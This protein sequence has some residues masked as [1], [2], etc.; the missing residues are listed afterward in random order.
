MRYLTGIF[1]FILFISCNKKNEVKNDKKNY[2]IQENKQQ[3]QNVTFILSNQ[4][5]GIPISI[6]RNLFVNDLEGKAHIFSSKKRD[7]IN[8]KIKNSEE[9]YISSKYSYRDTLLVKNGDAITIELKNKQFSYSINTKVNLKKYKLDTREIDSIKRKFITIQYD[10]PLKMQ[11]TDYEKVKSLYPI[12][13]N[14]L[15]FKNDS[16]ELMVLTNLYLKNY[17]KLTKKYDS[18]SDS[19]RKSIPNIKLLKDANLSIEQFNSLN[20]KKSEQNQ[21]IKLLK[22]DL[23]FSLFF[24]LTRLYGYS[25]ND[26][27]KELIQSSTFFNDSTVNESKLYSK[28][29]IFIQKIVLDNKKIRTKNKVKIDYI[30]AFDSLPKY[31]KSERNLLLAMIV[32]ID[33]AAKQNNSKEQI[34]D[35]ISRF[36][37]RYGDKRFEH[38]FDDFKANYLLESRISQLDDKNVY[39]MSFDSINTSFKNILNENIGKLIYVDFW[40][41]WCAPCRSVMP[42]AISL[43]KDYKNKDV[44]F[45]YLSIDNNFMNWQKAVNEDGMS[46][47]NS[48][49]TTNY[50]KANFYKEVRLEA[51]PRYLFYDKKGNLIHQNAP[52]PDSKEI[53]HLLDKYLK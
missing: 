6:Y 15:N 10:Y 8:F 11:P 32:C 39:L 18:I 51:I 53:R 49:I 7:T 14:K 23:N 36:E 52:E 20:K 22:D 30:Q 3:A 44:I 38:Y 45:L 47:A 35:L 50:P 41:S 21:Y 31:I 24:E 2:T 43:Q 46:K 27:I 42:E 33:G 37:K 9:L 13:I 1:L 12:K 16:V 28:L 26:E 19:Y 25:K 5:E 4:M 48:F 40:A 34:I 17:K 29:N